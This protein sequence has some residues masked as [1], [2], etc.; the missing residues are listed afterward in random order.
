MEGM[1]EVKNI[2]GK[3][4]GCVALKDISRGTTILKETP[5]IRGVFDQPSSSSIKEAFEAFKHMSKSDQKEF[6][7][8]S[9][10]Y[11]YSS[12]PSKELE[13]QS[14]LISIMS[15]GDESMAKIFKILTTN[16]FANGLG[17]KSSR[18]N[19]SCQPNAVSVIMSQGHDEIVAISKIKAGQEITISYQNRFFGIRGKKK[20]QEIM[21]KSCHF[22]CLCSLCQEQEDGEN[23]EFED[24]C[25]KIENL[26]KDRLNQGEL[27]TKQMQLLQYV[28]NG[29]LGKFM[30]EKLLLDNILYEN[31]KRQ[32]ELYKELYVKGKAKKVQ[33]ICLYEIL[34]AGFDA[35]SQGY[36]NKETDYFKTEAENFAKAAEKFEKLLGSQVVTQGRPD[37]WTQKYQ[38]FE[39][40][41]QNYVRGDINY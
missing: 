21:L 3:N 6:L 26:R 25:V 40:W 30:E 36:I 20:R 24:L 29:D 35:A 41:L 10:K 5:Q 31:P 2:R 13:I 17:I 23:D 19:H 15:N 11:E 22:V 14:R 16:I 1:Y 18:F 4:L 8:L 27:S 12:P 37:Q 38:N 33:T 34:D 28:Q 39:K 32:V 9:N 7:N